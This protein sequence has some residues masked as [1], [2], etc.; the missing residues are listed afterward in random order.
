[1]ASTATLLE[2]REMLLMKFDDCFMH[3]GFIVNATIKTLTDFCKVTVQQKLQHLK[4]EKYAN[5]LILISWAVFSHFSGFKTGLLSLL[6]SQHLD[7]FISFCLSF[8]CRSAGRLWVTVVLHDPVSAKLELSEMVSHVEFIVSSITATLTPPRWQLLWGL[9]W[10][11]PWFLS[12]WSS[13]PLWSHRLVT[14]GNFPSFHPTTAGTG[15]TR[16]LWFWIGWSEQP[17]YI[18]S[19]ESRDHSG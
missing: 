12:S 15:F 6:S 4:R 13:L 11:G 10:S 9:C 8:C 5:M 17:A 1:M 7:C 14:S 19:F 2:K 18:F 16:I 3:V